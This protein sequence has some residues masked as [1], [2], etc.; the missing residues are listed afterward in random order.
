[1]LS[2]L[3]LEVRV[4]PPILPVQGAEADPPRTP[5][6]SSA[7]EQG[8]LLLLQELFLPPP[9]PKPMTRGRRV[10]RAVGVSGSGG[11]RR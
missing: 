5:V 7:T 8:E 4:V 9:P 3:I 1:M 11:R 2:V 10:S 6:S